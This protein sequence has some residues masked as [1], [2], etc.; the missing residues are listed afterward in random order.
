MVEFPTIDALAK[1][2]IDTV[3]ANWAAVCGYRRAKNLHEA[4]KEIVVK[5]G[6]KVPEAVNDLLQIKGSRLSRCIGEH[7]FQQTCSSA[8]WKCDPR[9][10]RVPRAIDADPKQKSAVASDWKL[11]AYLVDPDRGLRRK[12]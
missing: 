5:Y 4:A 2:D 11:A 3:N 12:A 1:A 10:R 7:C 8:Q 6:G 9:P